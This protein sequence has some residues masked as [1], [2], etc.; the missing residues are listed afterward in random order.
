MVLVVCAGGTVVLEN[1]MNSL[2]GLHDR[3]VWM[4]KLLSRAGIPEPWTLESVH[5][6]TK[7]YKTSFFMK[8]HMSLTWKPTWL[9]STSSRIRELDLGPLTAEER[10]KSEVETTVRYV[11]KDGKRR[12]KGTAA[13]KGTQCAGSIM[14]VSCDP[15]ALYMALCLQ[16]GAVVC[17]DDQGQAELCLASS[18]SAIANRILD[19]RYQASRCLISS[20][21]QRTAKTCGIPAVTLERSWPT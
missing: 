13:L 4:V 15:E 17:G 19:R 1:P 11:G 18:V 5:E 20:P 6:T 7:F 21:K 16:P 12:F 3:H 10:R 14:S 9:W 2:I 8:K